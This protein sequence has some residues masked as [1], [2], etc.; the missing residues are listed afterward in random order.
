MPIQ[1]IVTIENKKHKLE[2]SAQPIIKEEFGSTWLNKLAQNL[3]DT[4]LTTKATGISAPQIGQPWR[5]IVFG[6]KELVNFPDMSIPKTILIN[7]S[8]TPIGD[9]Y[10]DVWEHCLSLPGRR[11]KTR[12]HKKIK[13]RGFDI[14][15]TAVEKTYEGIEAV[16]IQHEIDH[17]DGILFYKRV[18]NRSE[19]GKIID[20]EERLGHDHHKISSFKAKL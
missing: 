19:Y 9:E 18:L 7:P 13:Y 16:L 15:G 11:G 4:L 2:V 17:L 10:I 5:V 12:R 14:N 3:W 1:D 20:L 8:F 6:G